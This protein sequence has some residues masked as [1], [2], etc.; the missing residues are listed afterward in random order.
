MSCEELCAHIKA[1][2]VWEGDFRTRGD[3]RRDASAAAKSAPVIDCD[4]A[5]RHNLRARQN[6]LQ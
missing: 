5:R 1:S 6:L 3:L 2:N 4:R